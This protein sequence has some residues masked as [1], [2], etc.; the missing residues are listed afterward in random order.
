[1][2]LA[3]QDVAAINFALPVDITKWWNMY[4][5]VN[6][7]NSRYKANFGLGKLINIDVTSY[8]LNAQNTFKLGN[9]YTAELSAL[10]PLE[11]FEKAE[12]ILSTR[13]RTGETY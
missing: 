1:M 6:L 3:S 9:G 13:S 7:Y 2:N 10:L 4:A 5:S 11:S 8:S 12:S